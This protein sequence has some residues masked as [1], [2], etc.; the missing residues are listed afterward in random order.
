MMKIKNNKPKRTAQYGL[1]PQNIRETKDFDDST[2][3]PEKVQ[4]GILL[5][6]LKIYFI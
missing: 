5:K 6:S 3:F 4:M 2:L 1:F